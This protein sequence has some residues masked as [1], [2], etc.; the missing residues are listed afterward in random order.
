MED[1]ETP[2]ARFS[3][4]LFFYTALFVTAII[5]QSFIAQKNY[6]QIRLEQNLYY[7]PPFALD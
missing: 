1:A 3:D 2:F 5:G 7:I 6:R 4:M